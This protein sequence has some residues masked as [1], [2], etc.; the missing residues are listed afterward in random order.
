VAIAE[1]ELVELP[2]ELF[3]GDAYEGVADL[4]VVGRELV[5]VGWVDEDAA[6]WTAPLPDE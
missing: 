6:V 3:R 1:W 5:L 2:E 4:A